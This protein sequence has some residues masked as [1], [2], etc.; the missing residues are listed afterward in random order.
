MGLDQPRHDRV[1]RT[2]EFPRFGVGN[3]RAVPICASDFA[4]F[5][6]ADHSL[7]RLGEHDLVNALYGDRQVASDGRE[8]LRERDE[9]R[10]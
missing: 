7:S 9:E 4:I 2:K 6:T 5:A 3:R 1:S 10:P 8:P